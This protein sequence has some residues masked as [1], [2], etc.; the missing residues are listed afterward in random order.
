MS[1]VKD[2][3]QENIVGLMDRLIKEI[4]RITKNMEQENIVGLMDRLI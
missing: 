2:V 4:G 3:E 1:L